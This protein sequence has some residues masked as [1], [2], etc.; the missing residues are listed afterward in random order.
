MQSGNDDKY[1][2][3]Q[4]RIVKTKKNGPERFDGVFYTH[5]G[6]CIVFVRHRCFS[7]SVTRKIYPIISGPELV[8]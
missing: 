5:S 2:S 4:K 3:R 1:L 7:F 6:M 8:H